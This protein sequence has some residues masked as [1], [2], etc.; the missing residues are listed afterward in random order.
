MRIAGQVM[1]NMLR[2]A[3]RLLSVDDPVVAKQCTKEVVECL[4]IG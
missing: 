3:K 1:Q 2:S 4:C